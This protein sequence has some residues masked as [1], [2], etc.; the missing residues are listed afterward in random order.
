[1]KEKTCKQCQERYMPR[2]PLQVVCSLPCSIAYTKAK[3]EAKALKEFNR[4]TKRRKE[5][6]RDKQWYLEKAQTAFNSYI[7]ER[8][9]FLPCISCGKPH[10]TNASQVYRNCSHYRSRKAAS[11]LRYNT[12]NCSMSCSQCNKED[13]G[14]IMQRTTKDGIILGYREGLK[15]KYGTEILSMLENNHQFSDY[16]IEYLKRLR[17]IFA[18]RARLYKR[19]REQRS[20]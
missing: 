20:A 2:A 16:S 19:L 7:K 10:N 3:T 5:K 15:A 18:K 8:D 6:L 12:Y 14:H 11:Q 17:E 13:S 1:M 9:W 4:E